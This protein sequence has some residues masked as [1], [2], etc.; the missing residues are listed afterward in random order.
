MATL[1]DTAPLRYR[2]I[3]KKGL[4]RIFVTGSVGVVAS[5]ILFG[6]IYFLREASLPVISDFLALHQEMIAWIWFIVLAGVVLW[7]PFYELLYMISYYYNADDRYVYIRKGVIIKKEITL[8]FSKITDVYV[9]QDFLDF[10]LCLYDV[11]I[12]TPTLE[13]GLFAHIDGV[14]KYGAAVLKTLLLE[15]IQVEQ[16]AK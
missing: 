3:L 5:F 4:F 7:S 11:H 2:K 15:K 10:V 1:R 6:L 9:D 14:D 16:P 13:S 12:S 8:P